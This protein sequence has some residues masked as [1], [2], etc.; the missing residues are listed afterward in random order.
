MMTLCNTLSPDMHAQLT[1]TAHTY[2]HGC[3]DVAV[4]V[5]MWAWVCGCGHGCGVHVRVNY[6]T[7]ACMGT[8]LQPHG[9]QHSIVQQLYA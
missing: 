4:G 7:R 1:G 5:G 3:V 9:Q 2:T 8:S 6:S